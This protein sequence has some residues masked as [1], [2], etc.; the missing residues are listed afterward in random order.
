MEKYIL[1][2]DIKIIPNK[3]RNVLYRIDSFFHSP[4]KIAPIAPADSIFLLLF[5]GTR[6]MDDVR[7]DFLRV[8]KECKDIN[9]DRTIN[10][11]K[12]RLG[13]DDLLVDASELSMEDLSRYGNRVDPVS[14]V[15]T[16]EKFD[17]K[18]GDLR[19]D[20]PLSLNYNVATSCPFS[21]KYCYHPLNDIKPFI[22]LDRVKTVLS[23]FKENGCESVM[24]SA[25]DP[26][27]RPDI[28]EI[29]EHLHNIDLFY[30]LST[31]SIISKK[32]IDKL[33]EKAGLDRIQISLDS[34]RSD[35]V[36][37]VIGAPN[38]YFNACI[39]QIKYMLSC[40]IDVRAK[41]VLTSFVA[42]YLDEYFDMLDSLGVRHVQV[43]GYGRS[44]SRHED[45]LFPTEEQMSY[46]AEV[47]EKAKKKYPDMC[48]VGGG[49]SVQTAEPVG[50]NC[51]VFDK[52][53][54]CNAGRFC[55]TMLPNGE[56]TVCE[57]LPYD[58][59]YIIG[60]LSQEDLMDWWNGEKVKKWLSPPSREIFK[61]GVA[62]K[63]CEE[64]LYTKCHQKYSRC[65]R[66]CREYYGST[67]MPDTRCPEAEYPPI[68]IQ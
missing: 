19:L 52:R 39:D 6:T 44:G 18:D 49:Y 60:D 55:V 47:V 40:G 14:L 46:A 66:F 9:V 27:L 36:E 17:M 50:K 13:I 35:V 3:T 30:T 62:C 8:F 4:D 10:I 61:D 57:Q 29:M 34:S 63:T 15:L 48:I 28:D 38:G 5:D 24:L 22:P 45:S 42:D 37:K 11:L 1:N 53:S 64:G 51:P 26:M 65:L 2:P 12:K 16:K 31:K 54:V 59:R 41:S 43:V 58:K 23:Q 21:C 56:V 20:A 25:G 67:E 32:R 7:K 33:I 68:R